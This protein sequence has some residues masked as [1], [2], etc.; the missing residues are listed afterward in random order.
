MGVELKSEDC[1]VVFGRSN[2]DTL[3]GRKGKLA[4]TRQRDGDVW[5]MGAEL[6]PFD[7]LEQV[8]DFGGVGNVERVGT[9]SREQSTG[10]SDGE[11]GG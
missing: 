6:I 1:T 3:V 11:K 8:P 2:Q 4:R 10:R 5:D 9:G 7:G